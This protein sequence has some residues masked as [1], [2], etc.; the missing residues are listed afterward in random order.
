MTSETTFV[1]RGLPAPLPAGERI[2]WQGAPRPWPLMRHACH[3]IKIAGYFAVLAAWPLV[4]AVIAGSALTDAFGTAAWLVAMGLVA[5]MLLG[6]YGLLVSRVTLYTVTNRR[7]VIR[8]G[9]AVPMTVNIP[10]TIILRAAVRQRGDAT[11][12]IPLLLAPGQRVS[13]LL[14]WP[15]LRPWRLSR[16]E[17][18][19]RAIPQDEDV[20]GI[21]A[22]ALAAATLPPDSAAVTAAADRRLTPMPTPA[23]LTAA[24]A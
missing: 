1:P 8:S 7:V 12:D 6:I 11:T 5:A 15:H 17:P 4:S 21:L 14:L 20:A 3:V 24:A 10:F 9:I 23:P 2:L 18:M 22:A 16:P 19:L 13:L